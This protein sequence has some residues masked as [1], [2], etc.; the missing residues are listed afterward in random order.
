LLRV[1]GLFDNWLSRPVLDFELLDVL[2]N[3][4][5]WEAVSDLSTIEPGGQVVCQS[6]KLHM[7]LDSKMGY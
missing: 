3:I 4:K 7:A 6:D 5:R 2:V 1:T